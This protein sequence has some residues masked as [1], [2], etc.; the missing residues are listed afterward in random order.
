MSSRSR[1]YACSELSARPRSEAR[2]SRSDRNTGLSSRVCVG[3][4]REIVD[5]ER[6]RIASAVVHGGAASGAAL[7]QQIEID[8]TRLI[9]AEAMPVRV[10]Q[11]VEAEELAA[12][13][14]PPVQE[15]TMIGIG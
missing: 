1:R 3:L 4:D 2:D 12:A 11:A 13:T 9:A 10:A 14:I 8:R 5:D 6:E 15:R 7:D